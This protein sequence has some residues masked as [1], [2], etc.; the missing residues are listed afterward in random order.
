MR[1]RA[2]AHAFSRG[3][4]GREEQ[5]VLDGLPQAGQGIVDA[6]AAEWV[7]RWQEPSRCLEPPL[8]WPGDLPPLPP[9]T[10]ARLD[11]ALLTYPAKMGLG[12]DS[13]HPRSWLLL[14]EDYRRR[15]LDLMHAWEQR[16][17]RPRDW[18]NLIVFISKRG[19]GLRRR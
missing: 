1:G 2:R 6:L 17:D 13:L 18:L 3:P 8:E 10:L 4:L 15:L 12:A 11:A 16:P 5:P 9:L 7:P 19:G 14:P